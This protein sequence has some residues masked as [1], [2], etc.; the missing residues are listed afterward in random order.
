MKS[1]Y[2]TNKQSGHSKYYRMKEDPLQPGYWIAEYGRIGNAP[3]TCTYQTHLWSKKY[4]EK[5]NKGYKEELDPLGTGIQTQIP[6]DTILEKLIKL[7]SL[8]EN[9][10]DTVITVNLLRTKKIDLQVIKNL[11]YKHEN[12]DSLSKKDLI[13]LNEIYKLYKEI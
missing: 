12:L 9:T 11:I 5:I 3:Q 8:V 4:N 2:L 13:Q 6:P 7:R 10:S 1:V